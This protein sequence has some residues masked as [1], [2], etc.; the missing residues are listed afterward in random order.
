VCNS[1]TKDAKSAIHPA[2]NEKKSDAMGFEKDPASSISPDSMELSSPSVCT[3]PSS[4]KSLI[5]VGKGAENMLDSNRTTESFK[6]GCGSITYEKVESLRD[7]EPVAVIAAPPALEVKKPSCNGG[8]ER[9]PSI[10][11]SH[12]DMFKT[13]VEDGDLDDSSSDD[14]DDG[15]VSCPEKPKDDSDGERKAEATVRS[16][17]MEKFSVSPAVRRKSK[18][19]SRGDIPDMSQ[20]VKPLPAKRRSSTTK[21]STKSTRDTNVLTKKKDAEG[22]KQLNQY[23]LIKT[24]GIGSYGDVKLCQD[25]VTEV[26]YAIKIINKKLNQRDKNNSIQHEIA[27]MK[28]INHPHV[29]HLYEVID[30]PKFHKVYLV[31]EYVE[32]GPVMPDS[33]VN[34]PFPQETAWKYFRD[35]VQGLDYLH[36]Q[37]VVHRDIKPSNLLVAQDGTIKIADFGLSQVFTGDKS[38]QTAVGGSPAFMAPELWEDD[39]DW[40]DLSI[41]FAAD[42]WALGVTL[43]MFVYGCIPFMAKNQILL[44][45]KIV[46]SEPPFPEVPVIQVSQA[47]EVIGKTNSRRRKS[48]TQIGMGTSSNR[49]NSSISNNVQ[50]METR[51]PHPMFVDLCKRLMDKNPK[52]RINFDDVR[53]HPW[54]TKNGLAPLKPVRTEKITVSQ[55]EQEGA[56]TALGS[57]TMLL[58]IKRRMTGKAKEARDRLEKRSNTIAHTHHRQKSLA[59]TSI[60]EEVVLEGENAA[61]DVSPD[62]TKDEKVSDSENHMPASLH[63]SV[64]KCDIKVMGP[65][66]INEGVEDTNDELMGDHILMQ[67]HAMRSQTQTDEKGMVDHILMQTHTDYGPTKMPAEGMSNM[68]TKTL[69]RCDNGKLARTLRQASFNGE[70]DSSSSDSDYEDYVAT[71]DNGEDALDLDEKEDASETSSCKDMIED[72]LVGLIS[73]GETQENSMLGLIL[74][75]S[76]SQGPLEHQED[77]YL[78]ICDINKV[79]ATKD[80]QAQAIFGVFDGH[81]G[82]ECSTYVAR[83]LYLNV[84]KSI[85]FKENPSE[86]LREGC[87]KTDELFVDYATPLKIASGSTGTVAL[88]R[89]THIITANVGDSRIVASEAGMAVELTEDR[90]ASDSEEKKRI[91]EA[92]GW[93]ANK[94]VQGILAISRSFGDFEFKMP[95][96]AAAWPECDFKS[97]LVHAVPDIQVYDRREVNYEFLILASDG[98]WDVMSSQQAV[99]FV[100]ESLLEHQD[101]DKA[102]KQLVQEA[103]NLATKDN[104]TCLVVAFL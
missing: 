15:M 76:S 20:Y 73:V 94:R 101:V 30:D 31:L 16:Q 70:S 33:M 82:S 24:L 89:G 65:P 2:N 84:I 62:G 100:K 6:A 68:L 12:S 66:T 5:I 27:V 54:V 10:M 58:S 49:R 45:E 93:V 14:D 64:K 52:T 21:A 104:V 47:P 81:G 95:A 80:E 97:S 67:T 59:D 87:I 53:K 77:R 88:I 63:T 36:L 4:G 57:L 42:V 22:R 41:G 9:M 99:N 91:H 17:N 19:H 83:N 102:S 55:S 72:E 96:Q 50:K 34:E 28:K 103:L 79:F 92:G 48:S 29:V 23:T 37:G 74:G 11:N 39:V 26:Y 61:T 86:A 43:Y 35:V 69:T 3:S 56:V 51:P 18:R 44:Q 32:R 1:C 78:A 13:L 60:P 71:E 38:E 46:G 8:L 40:G 25:T 75:C 7:K 98:L 85:H 90:K